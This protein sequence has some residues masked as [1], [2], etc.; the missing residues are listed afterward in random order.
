[1][2]AS[3]SSSYSH[4]S[5][6][7]SQ[8]ASSRS[9]T[10]SPP[11]GIYQY[12]G[13]PPPAVDTPPVVPP[14]VKYYQHSTLP[15]ILWSPALSPMTYHNLCLQAVCSRYSSAKGVVL[16]QGINEMTLE[17]PLRGE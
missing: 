4:S 2:I 16:E 12:G 8:D 11:G 5:Q 17:M 7:A 14:P 10:S 9:S 3:S 1:M 6:A 15:V 13:I